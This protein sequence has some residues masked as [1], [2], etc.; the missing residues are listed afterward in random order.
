MSAKDFISAPQAISPCPEGPKWDHSPPL[1]SP[2]YKL[3]WARPTHRPCPS[4]DPGRCLLPR[5]GTKHISCSWLGQPLAASPYSDPLRIPHSSWSHH[6]ESQ[7]LLHPH[8]QVY[9]QSHQPG[10]IC[11][12][13]SQKNLASA[14]PG[15]VLRVSNFLCSVLMGM[16]S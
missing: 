16:A 15:V 14:I 5:T 7:V 6:R 1:C 2:I 12:Q 11:C 8:T 4:L 3:I 9:S 13:N 10:Q